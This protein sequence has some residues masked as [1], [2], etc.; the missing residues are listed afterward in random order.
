MWVD[1]DDNMKWTDLEGDMVNDC[2]FIDKNK[3]GKFACAPFNA[4]SPVPAT[5]VVSNTLS[6]R[7]N[8]II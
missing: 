5:E 8:A 2:L 7:T 1:D 3:D 4:A 6:A